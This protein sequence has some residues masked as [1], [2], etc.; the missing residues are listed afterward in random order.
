MLQKIFRARWTEGYLS[1]SGLARG[2]LDRI[3]E[4]F[5]TVWQQSNHQ[6][7]KYPN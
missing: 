2:D 4:V 5:I 6:R 3:A 7:I 1:E